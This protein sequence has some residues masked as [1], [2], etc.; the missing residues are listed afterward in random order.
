M[1]LLSFMNFQKLFL[2]RLLLIVDMMPL[3][4][5]TLFVF[6]IGVFLVIFGAVFLI[7]GKSY[8]G[9]WP[10]L[11]I[12]YKD[13]NPIRY[14]LCVGVFLGFGLLCIVFSLLYFIF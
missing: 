3:D 14:W 12:V 1:P 2:G 11:Y 4:Y 7:T 13:V 6:F 10:N 9:R 5:T 8:D